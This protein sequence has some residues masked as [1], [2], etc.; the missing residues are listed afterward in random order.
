MKI[1][2]VANQKGGV[3]KTTTAVT[4]AGLL[5][6]RK[7]RVLLIDL[8][9]QGS[10]SSYF[11]LFDKSKHNGVYQ[12]FSEKEITRSIIKSYIVSTNIF[13]LDLLPANMALAT[14]DRNIKHKHGLGLVLSQT[15]DRLQNDYD[16]ILLDCPPM[17]GVLMINALAACDILLIPV[18][19]EF[20]ALHGLS[21][22][23]ETVKM[24]M[25]VQGMHFDYLI[26]PTMFDRRTKVAHHSLQQIK[27]TYKDN[28]WH[29]VV[30]IDTKFRDASQNNML[31][32][33]Y[34]KV[35]KG[36][37]A[38]NLLL[39]NLLQMSVLQQKKVG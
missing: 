7:Q 27:Q 37:W 4:L 33:Q 22:M 16:F 17:V 20:L 28:V 15:L 35:T 26:V 14:I 5:A 2:A 9:P 10:L 19:T 39:K 34:T 13:K 32:S 12:L 23:I 31:P 21:G 18:Q 30:P 29:S 8:D 1:W 25:N 3:G 36:I 11:N 38:Y 6:E 24:V